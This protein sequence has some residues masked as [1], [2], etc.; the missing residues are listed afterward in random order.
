MNFTTLFLTA[1][2]REFL[3]DPGMIAFYMHE[4]CGWESHIASFVKEDADD[5]NLNLLRGG[6]RLDCLGDRK[7][8]ENP[9]RMLSCKEAFRYLRKYARKIDV[10]HLFFIKFSIPYGLAYKIL[11]PKGILYVKADMNVNAVIAEDKKRLAFI[12]CF[13][14]RIYLRH[15]V[16][17]ISV[18]STKGYDYLKNKYG[19]SGKK[20]LYLPNGIDDRFL[21]P[22]K[23]FGDKSDTIIT[24]GRIGTY[25]KNTEFLLE[26]AKSVE[27]KGDW[28]L[29]IIG[30]IEQSFEPAIESFYEET[31]LKDRVIFTGA[32][33]ERDKLFDEYDDAKVF[34]LTSR[35]E[36][37]GFVLIEAQMYGNY[38]ISTDVCSLKDFTEDGKYGK[39]VGTPQEMADEINR[40][41]SDQ[42]KIE[43]PC[44]QA[45]AHAGQ[46]RWSKVCSVLNQ[47][48]SHCR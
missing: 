3:K 9:L 23:P 43:S 7:L 34:C 35:Y 10:L 39:T 33:N 28:K 41:I 40:I 29:K 44:E 42:S 14:Y 4:A 31:G 19:L 11:H 36:S 20:L 18:E 38:L 47:H 46:Y 48:L 8:P 1:N 12:R 13:V 2:S 15:I 16:D 37:F 5:Y 27:W 22:S 26:A 24:V 6:V 30:P 32:I 25:Q 45:K 17:V 21:R